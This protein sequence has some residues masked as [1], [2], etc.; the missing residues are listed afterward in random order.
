LSEQLSSNEEKKMSK[1]LRLAISAVVFLSLLLPFV[2]WSEEAPLPAQIS[3]AHK[4][5]V[6]NGGEDPI[7]VFKPGHSYARLYT[8]LK[9]WGRYELVTG[10]SDADLVFQIQLVTQQEYYGDKPELVPVLKLVLLDPRTHIALWTF[11]EDLEKGIALL[12]AHQD[13]KFEKAIARLTDDLKA[14]PGS[15]PTATKP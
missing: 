15:S 5:F 9:E 4:V 3:T 2:A 11:N 7:F 12:G 6:S 13:Q 8:A 14:L 10:P 1:S